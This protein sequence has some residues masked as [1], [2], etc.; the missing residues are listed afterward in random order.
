MIR[1]RG[2]KKWVSLMLPEHVKMLKDMSVDLKRQ[3]KPVLDE[4]QIQEFE[5]RI[6]YAQEFK[7]PLEFFLFENGFIKNTVGRV[8]KMDPLEKKIKIK[9]VNDNVEF[10]YFNEIINVQIKD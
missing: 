7:L 10:V 1:D 2:N 4:Y 6:K 8:M 9:T 3:N 5:E